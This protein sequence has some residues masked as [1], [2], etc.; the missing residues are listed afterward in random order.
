MQN[1]QTLVMLTRNSI[2]VIPCDSV[3][4]LSLGRGDVRSK[5]SVMICDWGA[6]SH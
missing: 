6:Y 1:D 2:C 5:N 3:Q 4:G